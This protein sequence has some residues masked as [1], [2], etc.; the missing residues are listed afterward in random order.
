[1]KEIRGDLF[2]CNDHL[3]HCISAD[4][5]MSKGI[6]TEFRKRWGR[7]E[8]TYHVGDIAVMKDGDRCIIHM[9]TKNKYWE[10]P[11]L[12]S[13]EACLQ[14][15][16][17][18]GIQSISMPRIGCGLDRLRWEDVSRII[19]CTLDHMNVTVYML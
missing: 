6:A 3:C 5:A 1:M 18:L 13:I 12:E 10:K 15:V 8:G 17:I 9:I 19:T 14:R 2:Q 16:A 4:L 11:T 7:P